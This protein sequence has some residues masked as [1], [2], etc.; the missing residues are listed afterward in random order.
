MPDKVYVWG[1]YG[2]YIGIVLLALAI[3]GIIIAGREKIWLAGVLAV[4]LALM[5]GYLGPLSPWGILNAH[6]YPLKEMRVPSRFVAQATLALVAYAGI[7]VDRLSVLV[8]RIPKLSPAVV[9]AARLCISIVAIYAA[10]DVLGRGM[11]RIY[12]DGATGPPQTPNVRPS[13]RL[14]YGGANIAPTIDQPQ[15]NRGRV[16]CYEPWAIYEGAAL[17]DGDVP[18]V[19]S[20]APSARVLH[21]DRTQNSF[22]FA[23]EA[24]APTR[25]RLNSSF[26]YNW[27]TNVGTVAEDNKALAVDIPAGTY[28]VV[29]RYRPRL[30]AW[31]AVVSLVSIALVVRALRRRPA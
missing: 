2:A 9:A 24:D 20:T 30:L 29:V 26:D 13:T 21:D 14:H 6:V 18:Q 28:D 7:A 15:Q 22:R 12:V 8:E 31:G 17:W 25:L 10:G 3:V 16:Q 19:Q 23:V 5:V 27:R 11:E 4:G 1:E